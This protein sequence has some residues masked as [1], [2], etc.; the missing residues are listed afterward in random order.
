MSLKGLTIRS[1]ASLGGRAGCLLCH[2][3]TD[4]EMVVQK[5][6]GS[7]RDRAGLEPRVD[8]PKASTL[9]NLLSPRVPSVM[10]TDRGESIE[11]RLP[12]CFLILHSCPVAGPSVASVGIHARSLLKLGGWLLSIPS[13]LWLPRDL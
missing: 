12:G 7:G 10:G 2:H 4:K 13:S 6:Q 5:A 11:S 3:L 1:K 9:S 8:Y